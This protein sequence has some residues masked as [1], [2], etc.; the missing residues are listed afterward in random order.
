MELA[1][2]PR[3]S[4]TSFHDLLPH[5]S[6]S[7]ATPSLQITA[8]ASAR[9][10]R[11]RPRL[12]LLRVPGGGG[13]VPLPFLLH[14]R[15]APL[16]LRRSPAPPSSQQP[17]V[18]PA[19][20]RR[21]ILYVPIRFLTGG[22]LRSGPFSFFFPRNQEPPPVGPAQFGLV[23]SQPSQP[24]CPARIKKKGYFRFCEFPK[25]FSEAVLDLIFPGDLPIQI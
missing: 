21:T 16:P 23:C 18:S 14:H 15:R 20:R 10:R 2:L 1:P 13:G 9:S 5:R 8:R 6:S 11:S 24:V 12:K 25:L 19:S 22:P 17:P 4:Q 3:T 7:P